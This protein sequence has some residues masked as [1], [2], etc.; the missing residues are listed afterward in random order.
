MKRPL[1]SV[2]LVLIFAVSFLAALPVCADVIIHAEGT[3]TL[4]DSTIDINC[5]D[6]TVENGGTL[7]LTSGT[8]Q[9]CGALI[10][11]GGGSVVQTQGTI[12]YCAPTVTT[13]EVTAIGT[14]AATG[15]GTITALG[16]SALTAHGVCWNTTGAPTLAD[17]STD[18]GGAAAPGAFTS[19]MTGLSPNTTYY[20]RAYAT[21]TSGTAYGNEVSFTTAAGVIAPTASTQTASGVGSTTATLNGTVNAHGTDTTVIFE[22]GTTTAYGTTATADQS[23]VTGTT[24]TA[25]SVTL[26]GLA[27][28]TTY[29]CRVVATSTEGTTYG[30]DVTFTTLVAATATTNAASGVGTTTATLN[31]TV[32][33][34]GSS[35]TVTF[36]Y[37]LTSA[38][39]TTVT[40]DQSPVT[41]SAD[42]AVSGAITGLTPGTTYHF[43]VVAANTTGT[44]CGSDM[45][46]TTLPPPTATTRA[47]TGVGITAATLNGTVNAHGESATVTFQYG[48]TTAYGTTVTADQSPV[49]GSANT[50][51]NRALTGLTTGVTYHYRV[52]ATNGGGTAYGTDMTFITAV[53]PPTATTQAAGSVGTTTATLNGT[54]NAKGNSTTVNFEYGETTAYGTT[55]TA[56]QSPITG[57][58]DTAVSRLITGLTSGVTYHYRVVAANDGGTT[59]GADMTFTTPAPPAVTTGAASGLSTSGATLNGTVNANG[60]STTVTFQYGLTTAYGSTVT[61]D[62][63][64]VNNSTDTAAGATLTGLAADTVYHYRAVGQNTY[65]TTYGAD[66]TFITS[67][68]AAPT[69]VT[70]AATDVEFD[71]ATLNGTVN[72]NNG[73]TTVTFEYGLTTAYG[74]SVSAVPGSLTGTVDTAVSAAIGESDELEPD[75]TYHFRVVAQ[76]ASGTTYGADMT[77]DT[78]SAPPLALTVAGLVTGGDSATLNGIV[79]PQGTVTTVTFEYG[80]TTAY[81]TTV[82]ADQS[83][84]T[85]TLTYSKAVTADISGL[86]NNTTYHFRVVAQN[87]GGTTYGRDMTFT[88]GTVGTAPTATTD[89]ATGV[90]S[91]T[92]TLN[93]TVNAGDATTIITF[94][95]GLDTGYGSTAIANPNP[96]SGTTDTAVSAAVGDLSPNTTYHYRV[97]AINANGTVSG[98]DMTFTTLPPPPTAITTA[99]TSVGTANAELNGTVN[100]N[101]ASATVTFE[102]GLTTAYGTTVNAIQDPVNGTADTAVSRAITGLTD[103]VTYHYRVVA[104]ST[105]GTTYGADM[106]FTPGVTPPTATTQ[107]ATGVE[108]TTA[109]L[110]GTVNAN[111]TSTTVTFEYGPTTAYGKTVTATPGTVTGLSD[112]G[113]SVSI[114]GLTSN[115][116]Y[117]FRVV[118][119]NTGGTAYGVDMTFT[120]LAPPAVT[121]GAASGVS[122]AGA[123]LNGTVNAYGTGTTVTFEYGTTTAYGTTV[124]ADQDPVTGSIDTAVSTAITGLTADTIYHY[125]AVGTNMYGT[126]YGTD[127]TFVTTVG[128][129]PT[130]TTDAAMPVFNGA[131]LRG[132]VTA[133]NSSTTVTFQYGTTT[134]YGT[135]VTADQSPVTGVNVEVSATITGLAYNQTYHYRVVGTNASGTSN[136]ADMTFTTTLNP[137]VTVKPATNVLGTSATLNGVAN[138]NNSVWSVNFDY[139]TDLS[140]DSSVSATPATVDGNSDT[141]VSADITGLTPNTLYNYRARVYS[142][143]F[144]Y[145]S[146]SMTFTTLQGQSVTTDAA[147]SV[148]GTTATVN[149]T[150]NANTYATAVTFEFGLDTGYGKTVNAAQGPVA[151]STDTAVSAALTDLIP[152]TTYHYRATGR[153]TQGTVSGA[154]MTFTTSAAPP[155]AVTDA[156]TGVTNTGATLHGTV[157]ARND[158][159]TVT[160]EY[161][162]TTAYGTTVTADQSP[163]TGTTNTAVSKSITGLTA[164]TTY[165]YRVVAQNSSGTTFGADMTFFTGIMPPIATTGQATAIGPDGATLHGTANA[166]NA[167]TTVTFEYG[168][169]TG[170]GRSATASPSPVS[171]SADTAVSV[172]IDLLNANT[173]YHYR[174]CA[175][176]A[177][178]TTYGTDMT[179]TTNLAGTPTVTTADVTD[180][181]G[182]TATGGGTVIDEGDTPVITRGVCWKTSSA[183]TIADSTTSDGTGSGGFTS[184]LTD[185]TPLTTYY[186]RAYATNAA[187]TAY[188][189]EVQFTTI[190]G[191]GVPPAIQDAGPNGGD[192]N[193]DGT[194]DSLQTNVAS[195]PTATGA[196]YL[197]VEVSGCDQMEQV[198][199]FLYESVGAT[200]PGYTYPF[201][202]VG[203]EIPYSPVTVRIYYHGAEALDGYFYRK[204][205]PTPSDWS[206][207]IWYT[208][209]GV[210]FGT[211]EIGGQT[212]LYVEF[213]LTAG[214]LGDDTNGL[215]II[216]QGGPGL[217]E[218]NAVPTLSEWGMILFALVIAGTAIAIIRKRSSVEG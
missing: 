160:F 77:F 118:G 52:V 148:G 51:V 66:M 189:E 191:T 154:D 181:S 216:D 171:G 38:Y 41:G 95:Y 23:P 67:V 73:V 21:N 180:I 159:T 179:F 85:T 55:V 141:P 204:F 202:L 206:T 10:V 151:G 209:T 115:T 199:T 157:N 120:T 145:S 134:A 39:G 99:A 18:E 13:Q 29:H 129:A 17:S 130:V 72:P 214:Q 32:N 63:S 6:L 217:F 140:Y 111:G 138:A 46:F 109:T 114:S 94:E 212:V 14:T 24:D 107:A 167:S 93:G 211:A 173:I 20:V 101:G 5:G 45:T 89:A 59:Q 190:D 142:G 193:G 37:G 108:A 149:G 122:T 164:E 60:T 87:A 192:G 150:V 68:P 79:D 44:T 34:S 15:N 105:S 131:T 9:E 144:N 156:A 113:V 49:S 166:R 96:L 31:G 53:I 197:T 127:M 128:A 185:L 188:G 80:T 42:T 175:V 125:R 8:V 210:V 153:S 91:T 176:N 69:A 203:F 84:L 165:H 135:T 4:H 183:P 22:Y 139:S 12:S 104:T 196:G 163:V 184:S 162:L 213:I 110:N 112:T 61:A 75:T 103:G 119:E 19:T 161:G 26:T 174:V 200:D 143:A 178:G 126:T 102:Y 182:S 146:S 3:I 97:T 35:T 208:M 58:A 170:Y 88:L 133:N 106:T 36:E 56:D 1:V 168:E 27:P 90:D 215:P 98:A 158:A 187:G 117:H 194:R 205:G 64:P 177:A 74:S 169:T 76:N 92:A 28:G 218:P 172:A 62:Q 186:V 43:R 155:T 48:T 40:A 70:D 11:E 50:E 33:A 195:L 57:S 81:G 207:S 123:T 100:A 132:T 71:S 198:A 201:G 82:T 2:A 137:S 54:V 147:S 25:A 7:Q 47:A 86:A 121:T 83:P 136:G 152:G 78:T 30:G 124:T 65:G 16:T 116:T